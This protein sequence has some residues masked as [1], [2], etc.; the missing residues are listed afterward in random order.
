MC[1]TSKPTLTWTQR[2]GLI[3]VSCFPSAA[4]LSAYRPSSF[5][6]FINTKV[7]LQVA[8]QLS[9]IMQVYLSAARFNRHTSGIVTPQLSV[10]DCFLT[11]LSVF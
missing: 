10:S 5:Y 8:I 7:G 11:G 1:Q 2:R 4:E 6:V 9:P 3:P